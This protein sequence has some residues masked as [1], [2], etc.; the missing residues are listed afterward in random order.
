[1]SSHASTKIVSC[2]GDAWIRVLGFFKT[3]ESAMSHAKKLNEYDTQEIRI[4]PV[5]EFRMMMRSL[6]RDRETIKQQT[7][8]KNPRRKSRQGICRNP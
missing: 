5:G 4:A 2:D 3:R 8:L 7:L 6:D 1:M